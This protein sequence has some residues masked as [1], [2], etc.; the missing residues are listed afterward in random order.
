MHTPHARAAVSMLVMLGIP[1]KRTYVKTLKPPHC[2]CTA[3]GDLVSSSQVA[4]QVTAKG[5]F[6]FRISVVFLKTKVSPPTL[7]NKMVL[8]RPFLLK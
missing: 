4:G 8:L 6:Y 7:D 1:N 2:V 3:S 5:C